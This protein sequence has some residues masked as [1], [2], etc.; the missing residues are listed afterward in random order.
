LRSDDILKRLHIKTFM[1]TDKKHVYRKQAYRV[2][3]R[4]I[5]NM[6]LLLQSIGKYLTG[7][8]AERANLILEFCML[9]KNNHVRG[10]RYQNYS[11]REL[12][13]V[14]LCLPLQYRGTSET[15]RLARLEKVK[16]F[17]DERKNKIG[18]HVLHKKKELSCSFCGNKVLRWPSLTKKHVFCSRLCM[19]NYQI[20]TKN[21]RSSNRE[22]IV[23]PCVR[24]QEPIRNVLAAG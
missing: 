24:A 10:S 18:L 12:E 7:N 11:I 9:V 6:I 13:I 15:T 5:S 22:D 17:I 3:V 4:D 21:Y 23:R 20:Q 2:Q 19:A 1:R 8:K 16:N 14:D